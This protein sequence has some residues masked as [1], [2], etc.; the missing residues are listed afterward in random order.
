M[1]L[2]GTAAPGECD[3][4]AHAAASLRQRQ[5]RRDTRQRHRG[6]GGQQGRRHQG[7]G[8]HVVDG[9]RRAASWP[10]RLE[11]R[12]RSPRG[13]GGG[14]LRNS[15]IGVTSALAP[16]RANGR[17]ADRGRW[18]PGRARWPPTCAR[19]ALRA[20]RQCR[21][22]RAGRS[23]RA[24]RTLRAR[25]ARHRRRRGAGACRRLDRRRPRRAPGAQPRAGGDAVRAA[26]RQQLRLSGRPCGPG[27]DFTK[28]YLL[29]LAVVLVGFRITVRLVLDLGA[30]AAD[31][32]CHRAGRSC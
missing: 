11:G 2:G 27:L 20:R 14:R 4:A 7:P 3:L 16:S 26:D 21:E 19:C 29:R 23:P 8:A 24:L 32:G 10:L 5:A 30:A 15:E 18:R 22:P 17:A 1:R 28:R 12:H 6:A 25:L 31:G 13:D 9:R